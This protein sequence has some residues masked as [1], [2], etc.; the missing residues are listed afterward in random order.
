MS[1]KR[2]YAAFT[3]A[4]IGFAIQLIIGILVII[5]LYFFRIWGFRISHMMPWIIYSF[6]RITLFLII[7]I[8]IILILGAI[9]LG[10]LNTNDVSK[11]RNGSILII[12][13]GVI[14]LPT[15]LGFFI[16]SLL[17]VIGGILGLVWRPS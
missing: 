8:I 14:A 12:I 6:P 9:G 15:L 17:M 16:G 13:A 4:A 3:L 10:L 7:Y 5:A 2:P 11:V 1:E